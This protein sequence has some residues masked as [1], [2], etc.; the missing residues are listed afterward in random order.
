MSSLTSSIYPWATA[1]ATTISLALCSLFFGLILAIF[2]ALWERVKIKPIALLATS[3]VTLVRGLPEIIVVL[4]VYYGFANLSLLLLDGISINLYFTQFTLQAD[5]ELSSF[6]CG[7]IALSLLYAAYASQTLR[8]AIKA[9]PHGQWESGQALGLSRVAIFS[10]LI[11]PQMWRHALPGL[12][13]QWLV[14]L[15]DTALVSLISVHDIM[16]QMGGVARRTQE[17]F[18]WAL[19]A[20]LIYLLISMFSQFILTKIEARANRYVGRAN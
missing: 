7:V 18:T 4:F 13:N 5:L 14:L 19:V 11:M 3:F 16:M 12:G 17:P 9:V 6:S 10:R 20:A 1:T 8:G 15:K 2:L